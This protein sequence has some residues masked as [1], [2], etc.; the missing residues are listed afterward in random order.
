VLV[1]ELT[2]LRTRLESEREFQNERED[3]EMEFQH[4]Q[5]VL[6]EKNSGVR[7]PSTLNPKS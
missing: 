6:R 7:S 5:A 1:R 2:D 4:E 3:T